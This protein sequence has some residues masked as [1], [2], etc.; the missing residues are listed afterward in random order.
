[1]TW[2]APE[3]C[4]AGVQL[5]QLPLHGSSAHKGLVLLRYV[6]IEGLMSFKGVTC[7]ACSLQQA[8]IT[9]QHIVRVDLLAHKTPQHHQTHCSMIFG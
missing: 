2:P 5:G 4:D 8:W 9:V 1:M 7:T 6:H 3:Q